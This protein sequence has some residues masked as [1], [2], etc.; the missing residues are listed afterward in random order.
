MFPSA[1][2]RQGVLTSQTRT[3][4]RGG[5]MK[6]DHGRSAQRLAH[7]AD[8]LIWHM[9]TCGAFRIQKHRNSSLVFNLFSRSV[10]RSMA[11]RK[12]C[13]SDFAAK[14]SWLV[15]GK[16]VLHCHPKSPTD[17]HVAGHA[18]CVRG[19]KVAE[20][21]SIHAADLDGVGIMS[22]VR[23]GNQLQH[24]AGNAGTND[25]LSDRAVAVAIVDAMHL[26]KE[27]AFL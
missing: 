12:H 9:A 7:V 21:I 13:N 18:S 14:R 15:S 17:G 23:L 27:M 3:S 8:A 1:M 6:M 5:E 10:L 24:F 16:Y 11:H 22:I 2:P 19:I 4:P 26:K 25:L 20:L